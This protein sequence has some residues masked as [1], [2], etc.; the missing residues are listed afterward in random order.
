MVIYI[1]LGGVTFFLVIWWLLQ[2]AFRRV[3]VSD[4]DNLIRAIRFLVN[5]TSRNSVLTFYH[6][7]SKSIVQFIKYIEDDILCLHYSFPYTQAVYNHFEAIVATLDSAGMAVHLPDPNKSNTPKS[8]NIYWENPTDED[9]KH[10]ADAAIRTFKVIG[11]GE[12][13]YLSVTIKDLYDFDLLISNLKGS[14]VLPS[15]LKT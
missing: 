1:I 13:E 11:V 2:P 12:K 5:G 4:F 6:E 7:S 8:V 14:K 10:A 9:I 3:R 15:K